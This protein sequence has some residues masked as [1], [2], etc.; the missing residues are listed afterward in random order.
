[1][2]NNEITKLEVK[3]EGLRLKLDTTN[4]VISI[5]C[6]DNTVEEPNPAYCAIEAEIAYIE[7]VL[8]QKRKN[9]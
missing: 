4:P 1:M 9:K 3:L 5:V 8:E 2:D 7:N 6:N